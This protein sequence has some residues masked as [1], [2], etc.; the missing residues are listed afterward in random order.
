MQKSFYLCTS[1]MSFEKLFCQSA[2]I[3]HFRAKCKSFIKLFA[4]HDIGRGTPGIQF[5]FHEVHVGG[6]VSK[7]LA[8]ATT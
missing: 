8:V 1:I 2:K 4:E 7:E 5:S 6:D 3:Q